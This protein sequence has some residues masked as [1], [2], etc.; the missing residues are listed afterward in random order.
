MGEPHRCFYML[1]GA[2]ES[3]TKLAVANQSRTD[4]FPQADL[5]GSNPSRSDSQKRSEGFFRF[6]S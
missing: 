1:A 4:H 3:V 6:A 2:V 5:Q